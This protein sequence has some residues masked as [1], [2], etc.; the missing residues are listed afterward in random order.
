MVAKTPQKLRK[1]M[2]APLDPIQL[3]ETLNKVEKCMARL[4]EL[5]YITGGA[6]GVKNLSPRSSKGEWKRMS[7]PA[8]LLGETVGEILQAS[9]FAREIVA[10]VETKKT[11]VTTGD[12]KTPV[13]ISRRNSRLNPETTELR[14]RRKREK[15]IIRSDPHSS[16]ILQRAKS[17]INFKVS[18]S[19]PKKEKVENEN[20]RFIANRVSPKNKPWAKKTVIFPNPLFHS[21]PN[22]QNPRFC[23]TKSPVIPRIRQTT[24]HKFLIKTPPA[25]AAA[26]PS[27]S[28]VVKFQ[29]KI[30]S[31]TICV[32][33][34]GG[35]SGKKKSI[36]PVAKNKKETT[37]AKLRRSFS[38]SRLA[39]RLV[40][41][42]PLKSRKSSSCV[43]RKSMDG[44]MM[45][46][47]A[48]EHYLVAKTKKK[49]KEIMGQSPCY[50]DGERSTWKD[51]KDGRLGGWSSH[52]GLSNL[53][54]IGEQLR[55]LGCDLD[56]ATPKQ[57]REEVG[58]PVSSKRTI[59]NH[60]RLSQL[61]KCLADESAH[62]SIDDI[63]VDE[64]LNYVER[65]VAVLDRKVKRLRNKDIGIV[66]V[67]WQ[68]R[69]G[70][71]WTWEPEAE[72]H[73]HYPELF[74]V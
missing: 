23:R 51:M 24:P 69:K 12:P 58:G 18:G 66:K 39:N 74:S 48:K 29:V 1:K 64:G 49:M 63:Q 61:R 22:L 41:L 67:Q 42:S 72:M 50:R 14:A 46:M 59:S 32:S 35:G 57:N 40:S 31:P 55:V 9:R 2:V 28:S 71:E 11:S 25:K 6:K 38:P 26:P 20:H 47:I 5:Q 70:S 7:L 8:M 21:S 34:T 73:E 43:E 60:G 68:H 16:P 62:I 53:R 52:R 4:E 54:L 10:A 45:N 65:P 15:Q 44:M 27:S 3:R 30:R 37:A 17:R 19:P 13:T 36:S 56:W 33:P